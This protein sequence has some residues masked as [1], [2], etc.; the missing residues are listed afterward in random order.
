MERAVS[1]AWMIGLTCAIA[2]AVVPA[3]LV[4]QKAREATE[5]ATSTPLAS[6]TLSRLAA[7][8]QR[9]EGR[10]LAQFWNMIGSSGAPL[11]EPVEGAPDTVLV[12]FLWRAQADVHTV[13]VFGGPAIGAD[14]SRHQLLPLRGADVWYRSYGIH[15]NAQ[16]TYQF[17]INDPLTPIR[18]AADI[19]AVFARARPDPL[20]P[21]RFPA[22]ESPSA[23]SVVSLKESE[24]QQWYTKSDSIPAGRIDTIDANSRVL[25]K[26][27]IIVYTPRVQ[28]RSGQDATHDLDVLVVFDGP[29]FIGIVDAPTILDNLIA[30]RVI[31]PT[32]AA[33]IVHPDAVTRDR[34]LQCERSFERFVSTELLEWLHARYPVTSQ[35][36]RRTV[37]GA[38]YG[39]LAAYCAASRHPEQFGRAI[40]QSG[41]FWWSPPEENRPAWLTRVVPPSSARTASVYLSVG[42]L[43]TAEPMPGFPSQLAAVRS[44]RD[45]LVVRGHAV[46]Y[47]EY[48]GGHDYLG[49]REDFIYGLMRVTRAQP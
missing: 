5:G 34:E 6:S 19:Q 18:S 16:F 25:G 7:A 39:G 26:R 46:A 13:V 33:F 35:A 10:A 40:S 32:L 24:V 49:W 47:R 41:T 36:K 44:L 3:T 1:R 42:R 43:E 2:L 38:S 8:I 29:A 23:Q 20:N 17:L 45:S 11:V 28:P 30:A 21:R 27:R 15:R 4:A 9:G 12:T 22:S 14:R 31:P 48:E 37:A